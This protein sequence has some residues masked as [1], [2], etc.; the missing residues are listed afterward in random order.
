MI[1]LKL[2]KSRL[3]RMNKSKI[4]RL[5]TYIFQTTIIFKSGGTDETALTIC[6]PVRP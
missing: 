5:R 3:P 6:S 1:N 4:T 2:Y